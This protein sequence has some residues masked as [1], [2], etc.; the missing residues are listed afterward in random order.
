MQNQNKKTAFSSQGTIVSVRGSVIKAYFPYTI[1]KIY[2][3]L[4][5]GD[6]EE[7][8]IEVI[9]HFDAHT[10]Q[11]IALTTTQGL[12]RGSRVIDTLCRNDYIGIVPG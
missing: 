2:H 6:D 5:A 3:E 9:A 1:P 4:R 12:A 7:I 11:G 10:I 8:V